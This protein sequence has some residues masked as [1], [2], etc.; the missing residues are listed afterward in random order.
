M[1]INELDIAIQNLTEI[2]CSQWVNTP[3]CSL[4][5]EKYSPANFIKVFKK[6][7]EALIPHNFI[8]KS[9]SSWLKTLKE[10]ISSNEII[11]QTD[12]SEN[13]TIRLQNEIQNYHWNRPQATL[14]V[15]VVYFQERVGGILKLSHQNF[16]AMSECLKHDSVAVHIFMRKIIEYMQNV[17]EFRHIHYFSDGAGSQ[18]KNKFNFLNLCNQVDDFGVTADWNFFAT[19]HG[20][21]PCDGIGGT[22]KREILKHTLAA[23][24]SLQLDSPKKIFDWCVQNIQFAAFFWYDTDMYDMYSNILSERMKSAKLIPGTRDF[25]FYKPLNNKSLEVKV[26]ATSEEIFTKIVSK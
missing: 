23:C 20:K 26:T 3:R 4:L 21:G 8:V 25:H 6:S 5:K 14:Q 11:I 17:R 22:L 13:Y 24:P 7:F 19:A 15:A 9:Q 1:I 2:T 10:N 16:V 18:Y 12:F